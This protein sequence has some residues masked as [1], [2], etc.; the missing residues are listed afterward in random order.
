MIAVNFQYF[1]FTNNTIPDPTNP[2]IVS[3][4]IIHP[5]IRTANAPK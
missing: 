2:A 5:T 3:P 4:Q 1:H